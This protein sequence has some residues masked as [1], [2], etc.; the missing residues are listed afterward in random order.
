[1]SIS[2]LNHTGPMQEGQGYTLQCAVQ[3]AAPVGKLQVVF[4][5]GQRELASMQSNS[6]QELRKPQD[7]NFTL[8]F[9]PGEKDNGD[10][11]RCEVSLDLDIAPP[12]PVVTSTNMTALVHCKSQR[13][14][15]LP[16]CSC[17][18]FD[19]SGDSP[20]CTQS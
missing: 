7:Q 5:Q 17:I 13:S 14:R 2:V 12:R 10:S 3:Q 19:A 15:R 18:S 20:Q 9:R 8:D 4:Y 11:L 16:M 1:M 6:S